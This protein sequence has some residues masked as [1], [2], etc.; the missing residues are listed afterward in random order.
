MPILVCRKCKKKRMMS[1]GARICTLCQRASKA[2]YQRRYRKE[3]KENPITGKCDG[4]YNLYFKTPK[5]IT[6]YTA[7]I[8]YAT[9]Y[10][11]N[12]LWY[13]YSEK[14]KIQSQQGFDTLK[15]AR[16]D[17]ANAVC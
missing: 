15:K 8:K 7:Q 12:G 14:Y 5:P 2:E 17:A 4:H 9:F 3:R 1:E 16:L 6:K 10:I 11:N 13:W